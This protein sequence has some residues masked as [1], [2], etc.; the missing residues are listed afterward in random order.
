MANWTVHPT[1]VVSPDAE[2]GEDVWVGPYSV[3]EGK[4]RIGDGTRVEA[5][6]HIRDYVE[7]G[8]NCHI[9]EY[10]SIGGIPQD[11]GYRGE[12]TYVRIGD[13]VIL[14]ENVTVNRATG[15]GNETSVGDGTMIMDA[16][17]LAHNVRVGAGCTLTNKVGLAGHC[18]V[19]DY[20]VIGGLTGIHQ[21]V[22]VG[23]YAMVGCMAKIIK[24]VPPYS[25][26][27]GHPARVYGLNTVGLRRNGFTQEQRS[28][29]K[30]IYKLLYDR[31]LHREEALEEIERRW[32]DDAHAAVIVAFVRSLKRGLTP[33]MGRGRAT[34]ARE[35][36]E[37]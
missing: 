13:E 34:G 11:R 1:A 16:C 29:I 36:E 15:E 27:D 22:K 18:E 30:S 8:R 21:F 28:H 19:G 9:F 2:L 37:A 23:S 25:M 10:A 3:I 12:I 4:V 26:A 31:T 33:W 6:A 17:H 14:R 35:E 24:C 5:F 32:P 20:V 7:I